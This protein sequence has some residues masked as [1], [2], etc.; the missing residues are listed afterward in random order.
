MMLY[1]LRVCAVLRVFVL[2]VPVSCAFVFV[3]DLCVRHGQAH[4]GRRTLD[5]HK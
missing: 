4:G 5:V 3:Y 2:P 1:F